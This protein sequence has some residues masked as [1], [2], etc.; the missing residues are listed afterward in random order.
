MEDSFILTWED[1]EYIFGSRVCAIVKLVSKEPGMPK[2][3]Y[4]PRLL[5]SGV[6]EAWLVKLA[7]RL[8]NMSTLESCS[9]EKQ[10]KQVKETREKI[11][12]VVQRLTEVPRY[13]ALGSWFGQ[14]LEERCQFY[15]AYNV[16]GSSKKA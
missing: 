16:T 14:Q 8:H 15:E 9:R 7:D 12:L 4:F 10:L 13:A 2:A 11:M 5:N 1:L 6:P 3:E